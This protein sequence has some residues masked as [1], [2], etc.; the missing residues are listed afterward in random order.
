MSPPLLC[1]LAR[2]AWYLLPRLAFLD[3]N[4]AWGLLGRRLDAGRKTPRKRSE[5]PSSFHDLVHFLK[6]Y[7][8]LPFPIFLSSCPIQELRSSTSSALHR[9]PR[10]YAPLL[11]PSFL[12]QHPGEKRSARPGAF[13]PSL[14]TR[15]ADRAGAAGLAKSELRHPRLRQLNGRL[16]SS[17]GAAERARGRR[18]NSSGPRCCALRQSAAPPLPALRPA[19]SLARPAAADSIASF[20]SL[21]LSSRHSPPPPSLLSLSLSLF[22]YPP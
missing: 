4:L 10:L 7:P 15:S 9:D 19:R 5:T 17:P 13:H 21:S 6:R 8:P 18:H 14:R 3:T 12:L 1:A 2:W 20:M 22:F 11:S 16:C